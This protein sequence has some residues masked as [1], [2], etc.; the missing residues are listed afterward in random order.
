MK[1]PAK[2][3][4]LQHLERETD[5]NTCDPALGRGLG[6]GKTRRGRKGQERSWEGKRL[7]ELGLKE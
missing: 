1:E 6:K 3:D 2:R 4:R 5:T 7:K